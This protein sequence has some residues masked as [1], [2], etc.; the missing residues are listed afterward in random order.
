MRR[1]LGLRAAC[2]ERGFE[3]AV[4]ISFIEREWLVP[5]AAPL[6]ESEW[7][8]DDEDLA[9]ARLIIELREELGVNDESIPIILHLLDQLHALR[10]LAKKVA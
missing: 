5:E 1:K 9:R 4:I 7:A 10:A 8:L 2:A 3:E 6:D